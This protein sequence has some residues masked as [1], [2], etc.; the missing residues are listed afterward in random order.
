MYLLCTETGATF[1]VQMM[2]LTWD[3][4]RI[5]VHL[6]VQVWYLHRGAEFKIPSRNFLAAS[7][8]TRSVHM[9]GEA[10][11]V[12]LSVVAPTSC[13]RPSVLRFLPTLCQ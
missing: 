13:S 8:V 1:A 3:L 11:F 4:S 9:R 12:A 6:Q 7:E 2:W 10:S 5:L